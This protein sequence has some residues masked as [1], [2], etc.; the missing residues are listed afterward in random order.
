MSLRTYPPF[1]A[2]C[3]KENAYVPCYSVKEKII[4]RYVLKHDQKDFTQD[5]H[6][7]HRNHCNEVLQW[8]R[9]I[10]LNSKHGQ[11][12][13]PMDGKLLRGSISGKEDTG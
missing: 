8:D 13:G 3:F 12:W 2:L 11:V 7:R 5:H 9:E 1:I 4:Q 6:Y 10:G